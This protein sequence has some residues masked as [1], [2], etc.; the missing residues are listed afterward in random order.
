MRAPCSAGA[1]WSPGTS[2][3]ELI[4]IGKET[5]YRGGDGNLLPTRKGQPPPDLRYIKQ[6]K[7]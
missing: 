6:K 2:D 4:K 7:N 3:N 1:Q 5:Y